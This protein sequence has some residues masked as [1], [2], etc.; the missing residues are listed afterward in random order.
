[1]V[2]SYDTE[3][4]FRPEN[5]A[6]VRK[7]LEQLQRQTNGA[8]LLDLGCGTGFVINLAR[9]LFGE[10]HGVDVTSAMLEKIAAKPGNVT[11]HNIAA[12]SL[13]FQSDYFDVVSAYA[14]LHHLEDYT[15]VLREAH[16]VMRKGAIL[17]VDLEPNKAF[18]TAM[19]K[20]EK[21]GAR[22]RWSDIVE[23]EIDAVLH[24]DEKVRA[25]FGI[26]E[27]T[28]NKAEY[29]KSILGGIDAD[30]FT[31]ECM[32]IGF[33]SCVPHFQWFLGQ[34]AVMHGQSFEAA[35]VVERYLVRARPLSD[36]L[37]KYL[38][39]IVTK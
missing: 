1:M 35:E 6:K 36:H 18:W 3:P 10:I 16:R 22:G 39:F 33:S 23:K 13:P 2:D 9:D 30:R 28:F 25:E 29:T 17:Y 5:Q 20:L 32:Q 11:L 12:E 27:D 24:T 4:H 21:T 19:D 8:K 37:F 34:G 7:V 38:R 15:A 14:F 26:S 31:A